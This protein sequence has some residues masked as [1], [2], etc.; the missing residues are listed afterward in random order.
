MTRSDIDMFRNQ[1]IHNTIDMAVFEHINIR[2][3][4][5]CIGIP[6]YF[7]F[8]FSLVHVFALFSRLV[9]LRVT[10]PPGLILYGKHLVLARLIVMA[11]IHIGS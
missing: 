11:P 10:D 1:N 2:R 3:T 5:N 6:I 7:L 9:R 8:V 4:G